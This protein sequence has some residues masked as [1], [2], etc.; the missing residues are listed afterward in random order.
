MIM[1]M[2]TPGSEEKIILLVR[3]FGQWLETAWQEDT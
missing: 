1:V 3:G 2:N